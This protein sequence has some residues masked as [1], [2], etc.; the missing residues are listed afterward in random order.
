MTSKC[1]YRCYMCPQ[2]NLKRPRMDMPSE[3]YCRV[4]DEIDSFG[5]EGLWLYHFGESLLHPE[6]KHILGHVSSKNNLGILWLSTN[7]QCFGEDSMHCVLDSAL[8]YLN[9]SMNAVTEK[10]FSTVSKQGDFS[11]VEK[12]LERFIE[13]KR[14]GSVPTPPFLRCQMI[15]QETTQHEIDPFIAKYYKRVD[16]VSVN[17]LEHGTVKNNAGFIA[18]RERTQLTTCNK[19]SRNDGFI[20]SNG[21]VTICDAA[22]NEEILL[23]DVNKNSMHEIWNGAERKRILELNRQGRMHENA[24]CCRCTDYD[25]GSV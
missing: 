15:E 6:F 14:P 10:T 3:L 25:V 13:L 19:V 2:L 1:N 7:G 18:N 22:Y 21:H 11:V 24:F 12:N 16:I 5:V 20:N 8:T 17:M 23:G 4:V 9:Y